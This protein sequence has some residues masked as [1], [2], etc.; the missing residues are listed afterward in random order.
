MGSSGGHD[1]YI[2]G[3]GILSSLQITRE[4]EQAIKLCKTV[5]FLHPEA[6]QVGK[7]LESIC[8][9]VVDL[10]PCYADGAQRGGAYLKMVDAVL[11]E[12]QSNAP[13]AF[14]LYGHP[15]ILVTPSRIILERAS[16]L[17]LSATVL[18]GI[19]SLDCMFVDLGV[20]PCEGLVM[21]EVNEMFL[22]RRQPITDVHCF[23]WQP[24][25]VESELFAMRLN[26]PRRFLRLK[27]Y[28]LEFYPEDHVVTVVTCAMNPLVK[29][30]ITKVPLGRLETE[31]LQLHAGSTLYIPPIATAK[32]VD[33]EFKS[34]LHSEEHLASITEDLPDLSPRSET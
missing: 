22:H 7:Y 11:G 2:V 17:G 26:L 29:A 12:A 8:P 24:G 10:Q 16:A 32:P 31:S 13:V 18:P 4:T 33:E 23:I 28:L 6:K 1:I 20:D 9:K 21:Y 25:T 19:S 27:N 5:F 3:L 34:L 15:M 30:K 14:G